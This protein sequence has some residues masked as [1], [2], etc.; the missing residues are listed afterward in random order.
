MKILVVCQYYY[1]EPFRISDICEEL[2]RRGHKVTVVTGVPNYP[3]GE[4]YPGYE[5][6][7]RQRE[8]IDG[9]EVHR[10]FTIPR[11]T[12]ALYRLLNYYSFAVSSSIYV[13]KL[14]ADFDVVFVN[15]LS[16]VMMACAGITYAK[17]HKKHIVMYCLD[18]WPESLIAGGIRRGS[19]IYRLFHWASGRI[20]RRMNKILVTSRLFMD[21]LFDEFAIPREKMGHL[22][23][24]AEG[25]FEGLTP[26]T[27]DAITELTLA[28][29]I[30]EIQSVETVLRAAALLKEEPVHF[31]IVGGGTD[32]ERLQTLAGELQL[33]NVTFYGRRP[34]EEMP[35][36]YE[37]SDA[38]LVTL[39]AD[40]VLSMTLPGKVQ[41]YM[42]AGKPIIGAIDG[43]TPRVV[44]EA[45]CGFC[46]PA[47]DPEALAQNIRTFMKADI[48]S[49]GENAKHYYRNHFDRNRFVK[50]LE[51]H[52]ERK[53]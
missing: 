31:S 20:Y 17:K 16:P 41:S 24:Y 8:R 45:A 5:K 43:E 52:L 36:F 10:C 38:M 33:K 4:I 42:A 37:K 47:E 51:D 50:A 12:G 9:V 22:P 1:P 35:A 11:K 21:Y 25:L 14:P 32:L 49:F 6:G 23:Q 13:K 27:P 53:G 7:K 48:L 3:E 34:L 29:N 15:Q 2:V 40:P 46:G 19:M 39:K 26:K 18:L 30:G 28:G 44:S